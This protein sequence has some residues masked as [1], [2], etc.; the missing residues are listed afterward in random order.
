ML[1]ASKELEQRIVGSV[2]RTPDAIH[3]IRD[4]IRPEQ[5][6]DPTM[7]AVYEVIDDLAVEGVS[8]DRAIISRRAHVSGDI[9]LPVFLAKLQAEATSDLNDYVK[10]FLDSRLRRAVL[11]LLEHGR[12]AIEKLPNAMGVVQG[13]Q[14]SL[15]DVVGD[16]QRSDASLTALTAS[17][18]AKQ[19]AK[20]VRRIKTGIHFVDDV[21]GPMGPG[22]LF[23]LGGS[24]SAG[25]SALA[26]QIAYAVAQR[27]LL[28]DPDNETQPL[29]C[30][31]LYIS[32]E[33]EPEEIM[34]R[35]LSHETSVPL[36]LIERGDLN[37]FEEHQ[38]KE[39]QTR[40]AQYPL[41]IE[42]MARATVPAILALVMKYQ[43]LEN[44]GLVVIDHLHYVRGT[45]RKSDRFAQIEEAV[46]DMKASA[47]QTKIPWL[48]ISHLSREIAKRPDKRPLLSD[49]YG[50]SEIE[51][52][53]DVVFFVHRESYW[54]QR[55][56]PRK[57]TEEWGN[58]F[59]RLYGKDGA[60]DAPGPDA[61]IDKAEIIVAKRRGG[62]APA[63]RMCR[64]DERLTRFEQIVRK[65]QNAPADYAAAEF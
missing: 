22:N 56:E 33:M 48:A 59:R 3:S 40:V 8:I 19:Q 57:N 28:A 34:G 13:I 15:M 43:K 55:E 29:G 24:T 46:M 18:I 1:L 39:A 51:K 42:G 16:L 14:S 58:W 52:S 26:A 7:R 20:N 44:V 37:T 63:S 27:A 25:K 5:F 47:K 30:P 65:K 49:L 6:V 9:T 54:M 45:N 21:I 12:E 4:R 10:E 2:L 62:K 17:I 32:L 50:A 61:M 36:E 64:F 35:F 41:F 23:V 11:A 53:A 60:I 31:V 38:L